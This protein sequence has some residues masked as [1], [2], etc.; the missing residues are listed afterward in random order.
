[1]QLN[2][3]GFKPI[4]FDGSRKNQKIEKLNKIVITKMRILSV[5]RKELYDMYSKNKEN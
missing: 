1:M 2:N 3:A 5:V 4:E